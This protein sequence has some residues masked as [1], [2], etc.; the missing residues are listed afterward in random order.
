[1]HHEF[2]ASF[3]ARNTRACEARG[4]LAT[5][6][7]LY[8]DGFKAEL[9]PLADHY[10]AGA[11]V[12]VRAAVGE[13]TDSW[14]LDEKDR[15]RLR[16]QALAW[17]R[18]A[19]GAWDKLAEDKAARPGLRQA[20]EKWQKDDDLAGVREKPRLN[21]LPEAERAAWGKFWDDVAHL[22]R[23]TESRP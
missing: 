16:Q 7:R 22:L 14:G 4:R 6:A 12:A 15:G 20:L 17:M 19:L 10:S 18:A 3:R 11:K 9:Q 1:M 8:A 5:A 2:I 23:K 21:K 13:G